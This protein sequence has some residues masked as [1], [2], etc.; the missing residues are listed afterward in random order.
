MLIEDKLPT[1]LIRA[2]E[3]RGWSIYQATQHMVD[4]YPNTL[5]T[6][7]GLNPDRDPGGP[8]CKLRTVLEIVRVYWPDVQL[9]DFAGADCLFMAAPR[10]SR[11]MRR[12]TADLRETG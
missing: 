9:D 1:T 4:V 7:E 11:A 5:R 12:L 6:L 10:N 2:R 8:D 3:R